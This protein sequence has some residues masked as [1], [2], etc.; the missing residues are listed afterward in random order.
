MNNTRR[1]WI[2]GIIAVIIVALAAYVG[3]KPKNG[4][5]TNS[6][7]NSELVTKGTLTIGIEG[8]Y[9]PY[10]YRNKDGKLTGLEVELGQDIAKKMGLKAVFVPTKWDSLVAGLGSGR[11]DTVMNNMTKTPQRAKDYNYSIPYMKSHSVLI[12]S[13]KNTAIKNLKDIKG[14][15]LAAGIGTDNAKIIKDFGGVFVPDGGEF[16]NAIEMIR[17]GRVVGTVNSKEAWE[18]YSKKTDPKDFKV[19]DV[20]NEVAPSNISALFRKNTPELQSDYNKALKSLIKDGTV[21]KLAIKYFG[22]DVTK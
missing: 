6:K 17:Q 13:K 9:P 20:S 1:N 10:A 18:T 22:Y 21:R 7:L 12:V 19:Y 3:F 11:Y 5:N 14:K 8:T 2:I 16:A 4:A 15:K